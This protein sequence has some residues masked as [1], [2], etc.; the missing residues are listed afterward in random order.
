MKILVVAASKHSATAEIA[1]AIAAELASLGHAARREP[2]ESATTDGFDAVVLGSAVYMSRWM[3]PARDFADRH[4]AALAVLPTWVF[5]VGLAGAQADEPATVE[6]KLIR[7]IDPIGT[8]T[9]AGRI[10]PALLTLRERSVTRMVKA[11][12]G[13]LRD[14]AAVRAWAGQIHGALTEHLTAT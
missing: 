9:F 6:A 10:D 5:S 1:D 14:W 2:I 11:P 13:D 7:A 3:A 12:Q 4:R 8:Q